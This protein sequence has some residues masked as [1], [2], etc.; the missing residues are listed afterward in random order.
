VRSFAYGSGPAYGRLLDRHAAGWRRRLDADADLGALLAEALA[1]E[2]PAASAELP[3][4]TAVRL[5]LPAVLA[6][7]QAIA[8][9]QAESAAKWR[10]R[11]V[12]GPTVHLGFQQMNISFNPDLVFA[13]PPHG[14]VYP[15]LRIVDA[16]GVLEV[17]DG[18]LIPDDWA[19][20]TLPGRPERADGHWRGPGWTLAL[21]D[22]WT[23]D[24]EGPV[25]SL[26]RP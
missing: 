24:V 7:E 1:F 3:A 8:R 6:E 22:G 2:V 23:L 16:W 15:T 25:P 13:L 11:L 21:A 17:S 4:A 19:G 12:D 18:A 10:R 9:V 5:D 14:S 26:R 20:V